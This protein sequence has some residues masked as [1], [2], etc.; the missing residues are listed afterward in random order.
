MRFVLLQFGQRNYAS[1]ATRTRFSRPSALSPD[2]APKERCPE[3]PG[4]FWMGHASEEGTRRIKRHFG[5]QS[6]LDYLLGEKMLT[7]AE[8][9]DRRSEFAAELPRFQAEV[10][11]VFNRYELAG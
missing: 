3:R 10:W 1:G 6:T 8:V 9:A 7:F 5:V 2:L 11:S 4:T